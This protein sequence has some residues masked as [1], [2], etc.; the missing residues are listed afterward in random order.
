MSAA[1]GRVHPGRHR[2]RDGGPGERRADAC[3]RAGR[4]DRVPRAGTQRRDAPR[5]PGAPGRAVARADDGGLHRPGHP[6]WGGR[7]SPYTEHDARHVSRAGRGPA[8][9]LGAVAV[10]ADPVTD[11]CLGAVWVCHLDRHELGGSAT[12]PTWS[13]GRGVMSG[14]GGAAGRAPRLRAGRR[15][16]PGRTPAAAQRRR[17]QPALTTGGAASRLR[18]GVGH[19]SPSASVRP[20]HVWQV[21]Y[22]LLELS[23]RRGDR[24]AHPGTG[25]AARRAGDG[26]AGRR[27]RYEA[28]AVIQAPVAAGLADPAGRDPRPDPRARR[29]TQRR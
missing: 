10:R 19:A 1:T 9:R 8:R 24:G 12:G 27:R 14:R 18:G 7:L 5:A 13:R 23:T 17:R 25:V 20:S 22:D 29:N 2:A 15:R 28:R 16:R 3:V 4:P 21:R 26:G 6:P 11:V